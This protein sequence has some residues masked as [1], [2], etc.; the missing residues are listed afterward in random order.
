MIDNA[1]AMSSPP[2]RVRAVVSSAM[3]FS[4]SRKHLMTA[5]L[6]AQSA[7]MK[8]AVRNRLNPFAK[9]NYATLESVLEAVAEPL[10]EAG[11]VLTQWA[12]ELVY[13]SGKNERA[14]LHVYTR[15]EHAESSEYM[16]T[17]LPIMVV[18]DDAQGI[19]SAMTY[20]RRYALKALLGIPEVDDDGAAASGQDSE[21]RPPRKSS[22]A[23]K[24]DGTS[25]LFS[26]IQTE[27][28]S[29]LNIEMLKHI[30]EVRKDDVDG[31]PEKWAQLLREEYETRLDELKN[32]QV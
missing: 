18:K 17:C 14:T 15:I 25:D 23:A 11:L 31:M 3:E 7:V 19:G 28:R 1:G 26:E 32:R 27:I 12:G 24:K 13:G 22:A 21:L 5:R 8:G 10:T 6:K 16:Q 20:S 29:A 9:S 30:G 2:E 4:A